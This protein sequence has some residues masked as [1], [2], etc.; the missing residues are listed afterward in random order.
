MNTT[1]I[2]C[3]VS[4]TVGAVVS[5]LVC[6]NNIAKAVALRDKAKVELDQAKQKLAELRSKQ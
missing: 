5:W 2:A 3:I 6:S 1:V 4:G